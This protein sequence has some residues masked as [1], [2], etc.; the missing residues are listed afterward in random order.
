MYFFH[1]VFSIMLHFREDPNYRYEEGFTLLH[2]ATVRK[3]KE[4]INI[5][6]IHGCSSGAV[7]NN[8]L[9]VDNKFFY[10][11]KINWF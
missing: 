11:S 9:Q 7:T 2:K 4:M 8:G 1:V 10:V 3:Y 5:L 6:L